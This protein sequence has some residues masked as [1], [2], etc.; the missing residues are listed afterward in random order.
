MKYAIPILF[1][2]CTPAIGADLTPEQLSAIQR[3]SYAKIDFST[4][5]QEFL[6]TYP[7]AARLPTD[8]ANST[9]YAIE[10]PTGKFSFIITHFLG[11]DLVI[12]ALGYD[13]EEM[14]AKGGRLALEANAVRKLG[15]DYTAGR[16]GARAWSFPEIDRC[17]ATGV[18][19]DK[20][21]FMVMR[22]SVFAQI[23]GGS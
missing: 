7:N 14:A 19:S 4:T 21:L 9:E 1:I 17:I 2:L 13:A 18:K 3:F 12:L 23:V 16:E 6:R 5:R 15:D 10:D 8:N 20:W 22:N 11:D